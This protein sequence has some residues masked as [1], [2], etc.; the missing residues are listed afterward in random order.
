MKQLTAAETVT[1]E[2]HVRAYIDRAHRRPLL[3]G[4]GK[5]P[6]HPVHGRVSQPVSV[7]RSVCRHVA[8]L[9]QDLSVPDQQPAQSQQEWENEVNKYKKCSR[10]TMLKIY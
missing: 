3:P 4:V 1:K 10:Q 7:P 9:R 8:L 5:H 2:D 6:N